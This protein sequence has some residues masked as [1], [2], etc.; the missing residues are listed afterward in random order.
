MMNLVE[1]SFC[2]ASRE[3][4]D[5]GYWRKRREFGPWDDDCLLQPPVIK[6]YNFPTVCWP[7][8]SQLLRPQLERKELQKIRLV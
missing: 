8:R 6:R 2:T 3:S 7:V 4:L 1:V 5:F